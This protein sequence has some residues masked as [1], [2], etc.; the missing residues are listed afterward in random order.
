MTARKH[1]LKYLSIK[2]K[3]GK[4][5]VFL[6]TFMETTYEPMS[7]DNYPNFSPINS[8]PFKFSVIRIVR[9]LFS[10]HP[11]ILVSVFLHKYNC[12]P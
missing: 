12:F 5:K 9:G 2:S 7:K 1:K 3:I 6:M 11:H 4:K 8:Y 10:L